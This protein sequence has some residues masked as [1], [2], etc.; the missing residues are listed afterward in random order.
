MLI[1]ATSSF[2]RCKFIVHWYTRCSV[3]F[4][5]IPVLRH[6]IIFL[7]VQCWN[8]TRLGTPVV[9][10]YYKECR[11]HERNHLCKKFC[12]ESWKEEI[13][14]KTYMCGSR[15]NVETDLKKWNMKLRTEYSFR[16][17]SR[18][19]V[20]VQWVGSQLVHLYPGLVSLCPPHSLLTDSGM[21]LQIGPRRF[22]STS[23]QFITRQCFLH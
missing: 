22:P 16:L 2:V 12:H 21:K 10:G 9:I 23:F 11:T 1:T 13:T 5:F 18:E 19:S 7:L 6:E 3:C 20:A 8:V 14:Y 17:R 15:D 4:S